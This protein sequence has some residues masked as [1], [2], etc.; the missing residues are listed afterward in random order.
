M[1]ISS[2]ILNCHGIDSSVAP[3]G[4]FDPMFLNPYESAFD[5]GE[6]GAHSGAALRAFVAY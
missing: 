3:G 6:D 5:Y 4:V 1:V 2:D